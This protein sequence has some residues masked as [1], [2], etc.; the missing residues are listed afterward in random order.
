MP[1]DGGPEFKLFGYGPN[2]LVRVVCATTDR[3]SLPAV[4]T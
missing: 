1:S 3:R 2:K 4:S